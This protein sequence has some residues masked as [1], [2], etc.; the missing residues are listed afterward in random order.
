[1]LKLTSTPVMIAVP[2]T[3]IPTIFHEP[4]WLDIVA[5]GEIREASV[6][7]GGQYVAR[8][9]YLRTTR[10]G[11]LAVLG[12]PALSHVL[13]PALDPRFA[14]LDL[15]RS[16]KQFTLVKDLIGQL[17]SA[18]H[19]A[20][21]LHAGF[22]NTLAFSAAGFHCGVEH[23]VEITPDAPDLLWRRMRDKTRNVIR[24]AEEALVCRELREPGQFLDCYEENLQSK[25]LSS[26][27]DRRIC[28]PLLAECLRRRTGRILAAIDPAGRIVS[29]IFTVWDHASEYYFMSTRTP[30]SMNGATSLLIWIAIQHAAAAGLTFDMDG[31]HVVDGEI[32]NLLLL[33][34]FGG[35]IVT[36]FRVSRSAPFVD[37]GRSLRHYLQ[38]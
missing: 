30:E 20:F 18:A 35:R 22:T 13:G 38:T 9:P 31:F 12:M 3:L 27:Y 5:D 37:L 21:R 15:S 25:G 7:L 10:T 8:L 29:A 28:G 36:R 14:H 11:G 34:G 1:M 23:S 4:W 17:P 2:T 26:R 19:I 24:R 16:L 6:A 32:P 33:T